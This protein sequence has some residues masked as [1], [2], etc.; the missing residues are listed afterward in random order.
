MSVKDEKVTK[1]D[2]ELEIDDIS[3]FEACICDQKLWLA[4]ALEVDIK[5]AEVKVTFPILKGLPVSWYP[6]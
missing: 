3:G 2:S 4:C 1:Q 6:R 5:N